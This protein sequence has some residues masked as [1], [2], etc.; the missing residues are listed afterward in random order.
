M[1]RHTAIELRRLFEAVV[2]LA[3][4]PLVPF[5]IAAAEGFARDETLT[6]LERHDRLV[7]AHQ[8]SRCVSA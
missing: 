7:I 2:C 8:L 1:V 3:K 4:R 5:E 6:I